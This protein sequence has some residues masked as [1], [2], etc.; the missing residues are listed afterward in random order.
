[1]PGEL[2]HGPA[3]AF[4]REQLG[5]GARQRQAQGD[6]ARAGGRGKRGADGAAPGFTRGFAAVVV[7]GAQSDEQHALRADSF[8]LGQQ[9]GFAGLGGEVAALQQ[10]RDFF[11]GTQVEDLGFRSE[12]AIVVGAHRNTIDRE[13]GETLRP[14]FEL[15]VHTLLSRRAAVF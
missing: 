14:G 10:A 5:G 7:P 11:A 9:P 15:H 4:I 12:F 3:Q 2:G 1:V 8:E 6:A 13:V